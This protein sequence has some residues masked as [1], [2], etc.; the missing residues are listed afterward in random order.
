MAK[1]PYSQQ[2]DAR[3]QNV[4]ALLR[5]LW[6]HAPLSRAM[7]AQRNDLTKAT[8]SVICD[9]LVA[10]D[11]IRAVGQDRT[12]IGRPSNLLEINPTARC[13]I[14]VE[15]ST[16]YTAALLTDFCG[17][18]LWER[19]I[20]TRLND[21]QAEAQAQVEALLREAML[22][23]QNLPLPLL[24]I[25]VGLPSQTTLAHLP[26]LGWADASLKATWAARFGLPVLVE[27]KARVAALAEALHGSAQGVDNFV[28]VS[29]GTDVQAS[30]DAAVMMNGALFRGANGLGVDAGHIILDP[31]GP[32]CSCGQRGCWQAM[33]DVGREVELMQ[34][35][36]TAG[37]ATLLQNASGQQ[38]LDHRAIHQ[39]ALQRDPLALDVVRQVL[40]NHVFGIANLV[41]LFD[42]QLVVISHANVALPTEYQARMQALTAMPE[43]DIVNGVSRQLA[44]RGVTPPP[45]RLATCGATAC[46]L[47]A[48]TLL[49]DEFLRNPPSG[50]A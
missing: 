23:A 30:V 50:E 45:I 20:L 42:P 43:L 7:L 6:R 25:G 15:I 38:R 2:K 22:Q 32:L 27:N 48:A 36:L 47:G 10:Q 34:Q 19:A 5:D 13:V 41:S 21:T 4:S 1:T 26:S 29:M 12:G 18:R 9:D 33:T 24:G 16:N 40:M 39:A 44:S 17:K 28:Y 8:V 3:Q 46:M 14:G 49:V 31:Q 37:E 35:R 11:L